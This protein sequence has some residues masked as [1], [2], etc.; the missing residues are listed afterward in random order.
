VNRERPLLA[1]TLPGGARVQVIAPPATRG[2]LA[3]AI[4]KHVVQDLT[5]S[6]LDAHGAFAATRSVELAAPRT[7]PVDIAAL[8]HRGEWAGFFSAAV[9]ARLTI[10]VS[11]GTGSGKTTFLNA[12]LK[13]VPATERLIAMEDTPEVRLTQPNSIGLIAV[14]GE[15]GEARIDIDQLLQAALRMRPDRLL[16]GELRGAEAFAFLRAIN[17]GHPGSISTVHADSPRGALEQ[18]AFM[19]LQAGVTLT[20]GEIL[21]YARETIDVVVQLG[22]AGGRRGVTSV[23]LTRDLPSP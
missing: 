21:A 2:P 20:R 9:R 15:L 16:I 7:I 22:R 17:T 10:L 8:A 4:R 6:T 18:L 1:A 5:L 3:L 23:A 13:E 14:K 12:L 11:G 19:A